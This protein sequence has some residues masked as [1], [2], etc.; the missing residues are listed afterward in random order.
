MPSRRHQDVDQLDFFALLDEQADDPAL[1]PPT[2]AAARSAAEHRPQP[3]TR[4]AAGRP[5]QHAAADPAPAEPHG[6]ADPT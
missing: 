4:P 2:P 3:A 5:A 1:D 6:S